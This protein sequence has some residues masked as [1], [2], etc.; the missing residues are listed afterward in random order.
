[1]LRKLLLIL[2]T[3]LLMGGMLFLVGETTSPDVAQALVCYNLPGPS[4]SRMAT[5][6]YMSGSQYRVTSISSWAP[7]SAPG[8]WHRPACYL[9]NSR[10]WRYGTWTQPGYY[11]PKLVLNI[12]YCSSISV[13]F[14]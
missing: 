5:C 2:C 8:T 9:S 14:K 12:G 11:S 3:S 4:G 13:S 10:V 6:G 7:S 1:M